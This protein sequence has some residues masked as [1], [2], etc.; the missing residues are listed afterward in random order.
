M[1]STPSQNS[2]VNASPSPNVPEAHGC[3]TILNSFQTS[4]A[5]YIAFV[6]A[7]ICNVMSD[8]VK[9]ANTGLIAGGVAVQFTVISLKLLH[10][11]KA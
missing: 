1:V 4:A 11:A 2:Q 10:L 3:S 8:K 6:P 9:Y 7:G 5:S